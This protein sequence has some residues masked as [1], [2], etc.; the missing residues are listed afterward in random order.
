MATAMSVSAVAPA[1]VAVARPRTLVCVP[2]TARAP[3]EMAAELAAAAAIGVDVAE[4]RLD[5]LAGFAPRRD[6]PV[7]L[8]E[9]RPLSALVTYRL[10]C[11]APSPS[12]TAP[13]LLMCGD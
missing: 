9:P 5:R 3:R 7:L 6:L 10:V 1:A 2:A 4:L 8:A 12:C 13:R 11:L